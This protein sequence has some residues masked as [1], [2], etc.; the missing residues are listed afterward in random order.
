MI[1]AQHA[2]KKW[3]QT[4]HLTLGLS[5]MAAFRVG[6][7]RG[8][9]GFLCLAAFLTLSTVHGVSLQLRLR[10]VSRYQRQ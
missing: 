9:D 1:T 3:R 8:L 7:T 6:L 10:L 5:C 2:W 4:N